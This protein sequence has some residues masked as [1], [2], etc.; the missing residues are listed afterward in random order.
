MAKKTVTSINRRKT[1]SILPMRMPTA[2]AEGF[3]DLPAKGKR[4]SSAFGLMDFKFAGLPLIIAGLV[5]SMIALVWALMV[6]AQQSSRES[7]YIE[8]SSQLLMLSQRIAK[9]AREAVLGQKIAFGTLKDSRNQFET[10][11]NNLRLGSADVGIPPTSEDS[12][13]GQALASVIK[14]WAPKPA[15]AACLGRHHRPAGKGGCAMHE[16]VEQINQSAPL[17]LTI[18]DEIIEDG[19]SSACTARAEPCRLAGRVVAAHRQGRQ[20]LCPGR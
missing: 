2:A 18:L 20:Y 12:H 19:T 9:D 17:L 13:S 5:L 16:H 4:S 7:K 14:L 3:V 1:S 15:K 6:N 10:I 11:V 8:Q